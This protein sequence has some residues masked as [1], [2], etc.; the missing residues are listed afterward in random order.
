MPSDLTA[1]VFRAVDATDVPA[2]VDLFTPDGSMTFGNSAPLSGREAIAAGL[3]AFYAT[4]SGLRHDIR[5]EWTVGA[6]T[7]VEA[8]V[9]YSLPDGRE[10]PVP[11]VT[12]FHT[13]GGGLIDDYRIFIDLAPLA[14]G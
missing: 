14:A 4:L 11:A 3:T 7:V 12:I 10:V 8:T 5:N 13:D 9:T 1:R 6:D 2:F